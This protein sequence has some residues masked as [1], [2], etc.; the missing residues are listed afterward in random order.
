MFRLV[1]LGA[2][3]E[4]RGYPAAVSADVTVTVS[5]PQRPANTG[6]WRLEIADGACQVT[7]AGPAPSH[8]RAPELGIGGMS[9]LFAGIPTGTLRRAGLMTGPSG[10][11]EALDAAFAATPYML[12]YF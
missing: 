7:P 10:A 6:T 12:D 4:G 8:G 3:L 5:D 9:A 11:D 2:A 1:D